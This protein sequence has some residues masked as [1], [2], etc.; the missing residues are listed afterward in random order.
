MQDGQ[1]A[2]SVA[3]FLSLKQ[4]F[5]A[6]Y[7]SK[8]SSRPDCIFEIHQRW[9]SGFSRVYSNC[10]CSF[11]FEPKIIKIGQS[12]HKMY[13]NKIVN[14]QAST[15]ILNAYT[16]MFENLLNTPRIF[17]QR[18]GIAMG[19]VWGNIFSTYYIS[20][21]EN[22]D[23]I[24]ENKVFLSSKFNTINI[25]LRYA[26]YILLTNSSDQ[27]NKI[28]ETFQNNSILNFT[29]EI[30]INNKIPSI[31]VLTDT[32]N[33]ERFITSAYKKP[34]NINPCTLNFQSECPFCYKR[35]IIKTLIPRAKL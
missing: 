3:F 18:D 33:I 17:I 32:S 35:I 9:Q 6:Y 4:N 13:S 11:S 23:L 31:G 34:T 26:D 19:S 29:K 7:S 15:T 8:V 5:I 25:Y 1:K 20:A 24:L 12:S 22:T 27:I 21:L 28:K 10:C 30:N 2:V 14:V 16:K